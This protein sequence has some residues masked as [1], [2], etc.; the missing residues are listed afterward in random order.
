MMRGVLCLVCGLCIWPAM[1]DTTIV[2]PDRSLKVVFVETV[3]S[4][5]TRAKE[6][7]LK[8][9]DKRGNEVFAKDYTSGDGEHGSSLLNAKWTPD[10]QYLVY[11]STSSG[12]HQSWRIPI[13]VYARKR[14]E[15]VDLEQIVGDIVDDQF[16]IV[17]PHTVIVTSRDAN[18]L[19]PKDVTLNLS[20]IK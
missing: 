19:Q 14:N 2:S 11:A 20:K 3:R 1:A 16:R 15:V 9:R 13:H 17:A 5:A 10:S 6:F 7:V 4:Q 8:I 12:G 18:T